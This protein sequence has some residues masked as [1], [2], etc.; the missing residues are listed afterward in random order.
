MTKARAIPATP[1]TTPPTT[2]CCVGVSPGL[3]AE[4]VSDS[5]AAE[6]VVVSIGEPTVPEAA[7]P[8]KLVTGAVL[9]SRGSLEDVVNSWPKVYGVDEAVEAA[10][11]LASGVGVR[12]LPVAK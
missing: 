10:V 4:L 12:E 1:P 8:G 3:G 2:V 11:I 7:T 9:V 5:G 6:E